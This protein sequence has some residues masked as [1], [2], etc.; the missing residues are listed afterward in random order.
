M[1]FNDVFI[2]YYVL[3][4][5]IGLL[6][7]KFVAWCNIRIPEN[8]EIFSF[9]FFKENKSGLRLNYT[10]MIIIAIIYV[11]LLYKFGIKK[12]DIFKNLDLIKFLILTPM[13]VLA[14][15]IDSKYRIIPNRLNLS[16]LEFG[17]VI[18]FIY[19]IS[20]VNMAKDYIL[21]MLVGA[22][23]FGI[24]FILGWIVAGKEAMGLGDVKFMTA[25]GLYFGPNS[26]IEISL[27]S[28]IVGAICSILL[29]FI[30]IVIL[31]KKDDYVAFGP[32]L[33]I[34]AMACIFLPTNFILDTFLDFCKIISN[35]IVL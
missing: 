17:L 35:N 25:I 15:S 11:S 18:T 10:F 7:G 19:G 30:R 29:I 9:E 21:G 2:G 28:F 31:K 32:F 12:D 20:N 34:A 26:I 6:V 13:L 33:S 4:A 14:F 24:I 8:K 3:I 1:Y 16:L 22:G 5:F 23:I 27:F